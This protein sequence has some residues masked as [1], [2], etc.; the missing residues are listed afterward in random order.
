MRTTRFVVLGSLTT[1]T[2]LCFMA[3]W[4]AAQDFE[5]RSCE[6]GPL[7]IS[8]LVTPPRARI[9][10]TLTIEP[11]SQSLESESMEFEG[12]EFPPAQPP[13]PVAH[14]RPRVMASVAPALDPTLTEPGDAVRAALRLKRPALEHCYEEE[15]KKQAAFDGF[16]VVAISVA[17]N[18]TVL[19]ASV[20]EA[21]RRDARV[22]ACIVAQLKRLKLPPL[23]EEADL[24]I[25][26]RL[27]SKQLATRE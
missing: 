15:L 9:E 8:A 26:I 1:A 6:Q 20:E 25:P 17:A 4:E 7:G 24:Q 16:V 27:Q 2:A 5:T 3:S 12:L 14:R 19:G 13:A 22:G 21:G 10:P 23:T 18:G 11:P